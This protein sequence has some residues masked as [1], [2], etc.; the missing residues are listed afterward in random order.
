MSGRRRR[1]RRNIYTYPGGEKLWINR[2]LKWEEEIMVGYI[3]GA[4]EESEE[5]GGAGEVDARRGDDEDN[6]VDLGG[7]ASKH[8]EGSDTDPD[9][10]N[11]AWLR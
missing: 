6:P 8:G 4:G 9:M 3:E 10:P 1:G 11:S 5:T 2:E 7:E